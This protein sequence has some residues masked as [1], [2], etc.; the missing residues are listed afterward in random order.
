MYNNMPF[1]SE[2]ENI[3]YP[4]VKLIILDLGFSIDVFNNRD[5]F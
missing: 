5:R 2:W 3:I 1:F 4:L